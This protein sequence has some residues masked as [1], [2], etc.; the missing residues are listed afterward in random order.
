MD[1][2]NGSPTMPRNAAT[3][4]TSTKTPG[5][6]RADCDLTVAER[7]IEHSDIKV[8]L[9][10]CIRWF[11]FGLAAFITALTGFIIALYSIHNAEPTKVRRPIGERA[12][13]AASEVTKQAIR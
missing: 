3:T 9:A 6:V 5:K 12:L 11:W 13:S 8:D 2:A 1:K 4:T 7:L 10:A